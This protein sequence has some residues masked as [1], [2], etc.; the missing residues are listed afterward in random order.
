M[1]FEEKTK[2]ITVLLTRKY[3]HLSN[4]IYWISGRGY[5]HASIALDT[6]HDFFYSFNFKGFCIENFSKRKHLRRKNMSVCYHLNISE[7]AYNDISLKISEFI[8]QS[9][10][11]RYSRLGVLLCLLHIP[12]KIKNNYFCSQF[13]AELLSLSDEIQLKKGTSL[14]LPNQ[15]VKELEEQQFLCNKIYGVV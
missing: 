8:D 5:T 15:F 13:V 9:T 1:K 14:Y 10:K 12:H 11:Y 7:A 6:N 3:D 2:I 4:L